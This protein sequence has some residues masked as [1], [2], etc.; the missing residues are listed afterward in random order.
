M[1]LNGGA[2]LMFYLQ[3]IGEVVEYFPHVVYAAGS[4]TGSAT[5]ST[6]GASTLRVT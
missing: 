6:A 2:E 5:V 4:V 1:P 3:E